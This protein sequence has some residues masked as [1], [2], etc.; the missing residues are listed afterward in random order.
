VARL[1]EM[2]EACQNQQPINCATLASSFPSSV[3]ASGYGGDEYG[4]F[5]LSEVMLSKQL[6]AIFSDKK[7]IHGDY[8][9]IHPLDFD[10]TVTNWVPR[11]DCPLDEQLYYYRYRRDDGGYIKAA[12]C[13]LEDKA[14]VDLDCWGCENIKDAA[15]KDPQGRSPAHWIS[16]RLNIHISRQ[17]LRL[18]G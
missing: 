13:T 11:V 1:S 14:Y 10:G 15:R 3:V 9:S 7:V 12:K 16:V 5:N 8:A 18:V 17:I 2:L 6:K 4:R